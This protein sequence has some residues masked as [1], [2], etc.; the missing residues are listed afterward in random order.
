MREYPQCRNI[1]IDGD[2]Y[3]D[4]FLNLFPSAANKQKKAH[5]EDGVVRVLD[6]LGKTR[7][8]WALLV[9]IFYLPKCMMTIRPYHPDPKWG[10]CNAL[11]K[12]ENRSDATMKDTSVPGQPG[13]SGTGVG[14]NTEITY[15][16]DT[17]TPP[18]ACV[19]G[20]GATADEI[21]LHEM[22]HGVRQMMGRSVN[23]TISGNPGMDNYEEFLAILVSN[24]FRSERGT[25]QLRMDHHGFAPL[26][27]PTVDPAVFASTYDRYLSYFDVEQPRFCKN[28]RTIKASFNPTIFMGGGKP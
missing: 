3:T 25:S 10:V 15:D 14:S 6:I 11:T 26:S 23:E 5:F 8:G 4:G 28:L 20:P 21:L 27:G 1:H 18:S 22:I 19:S 13:A 17:F 12:A 9:E 24:I 7:T 2:E 16:P